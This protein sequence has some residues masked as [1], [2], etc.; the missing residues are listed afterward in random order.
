MH[1]AAAAMSALL[2]TT[3]AQWRADIDYLASELPKR[4]PNPFHDTTQAAF[5]AQLAALKAKV[6]GM[7][8][9]DVALALQQAVASLDDA[10][11][12]VDTRI[13]ANLYFPLRFDVFD[14]G[15]FVVK[16]APELGAARRAT[17]VPGEMGRQAQASTA[18][19]G[20]INASSEWPLHLQKGSQNYWFTWDAARGLLY[21]KYNLCSD[22]APSFASMVRDVFAIADAQTV[23]RFV[24][25]LRNNPGGNSQVV[26]PLIDALRARPAWRG[27]LYAI[28]NR[29]TISSGLL[30]AL[31]LRNAG[32][33]LAGEPTGGKPNSYGDQRS[34]QLPNSRLTVFH[35]TKYFDLVPGD[36]P[37]LA[38]D[39]A[40]TITSNDFF[41]R[42]DPVL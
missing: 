42:R 6:D 24:V 18:I 1:F 33:V 10:H 36:P 37:A 11:T 26:Q 21:I 16:T 32:A 14:D 39:I 15:I 38:P 17:L 41:A 5:N 13:G 35:S 9:V 4:H 7:S 40:V 34:F 25:D 29:R 27:R 8:D 20:A 28:I 2:L 3:P 23:Q 30:A 22:S 31:D 19:F 12:E